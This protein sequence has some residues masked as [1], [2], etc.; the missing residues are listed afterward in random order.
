[1][2]IKYETEFI[3]SKSSEYDKIEPSKEQS[4]FLE[5]YKSLLKSSPSYK[6]FDRRNS[7]NYHKNYNNDNNLNFN[8]TLI[9]RK[10]NAWIPS[11]NS[12]DITKKIRNIL[13]KISYDNKNKTIKSLTTGLL[14]IEDINVLSVLSKLI[15][16][17]IRFD[18]DYYDIYLSICETVWN[19]HKWHSKLIEP[20]IEFNAENNKFYY[21]LNENC[22]KKGPFDNK[23]LIYNALNFKNNVTSLCKYEF[24]QIDSVIDEINGSD[25]DEYIYKRKRKI[26]GT[27]E[28]IGHL[29]KR[30]V[31][32]PDIIKYCINTL[33]KI[34][35]NSES[36]KEQHIECIKV[37]LDIVNDQK[38]FDS[39]YMNWLSSHMKNVILK[40][41]WNTRIMFMIDDIINSGFS[42]PKKII[43]KK[44]NYEPDEVLDM[45]M[46]NKNLNKTYQHVKTGSVKEY[47]QLILY[48]MIDDVRKHDVLLPLMRKI[49]NTK[50]ATIKEINNNLIE[51]VTNIDDL[52]IDIPKA[53]ENIALSAIKIAK[54]LNQK[55]LLFNKSINKSK[56]SDNTKKH[57]VDIYKHI[58]V[59]KENKRYLVNTFYTKEIFNMVK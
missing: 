14:K 25:D 23:Y 10:D 16:D 43:S 32:T 33:V 39:N 27:L 21:K 13:N 2:T 29:Y 18:K 51:H 58:L 46:K 28:F 1:M 20:I 36:I 4:D 3:L 53:V 12:N 26:F 54:T 41:K 38:Y 57:I 30:N 19:M 55:V 17:K 37:L 7:N 42:K 34:Q 59:N 6:K 50:L 15:L 5:S 8:K 48:F 56:L 35:T 40:K 9:K 11:K 47:I 24:G 44:E 22:D 49:Y 45:Y 52:L 31:L